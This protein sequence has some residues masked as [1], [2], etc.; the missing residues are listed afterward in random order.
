MIHSLPLSLSLSRSAYA[1]IELSNPLAVDVTV[2]CEQ[3]SQ[4]FIVVGLQDGQVQ[5]CGCYGSMVTM[6]TLDCAACQLYIADIIDVQ[7]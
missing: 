7:A 4:C 6:V 3:S 1:T 5:C 2:L